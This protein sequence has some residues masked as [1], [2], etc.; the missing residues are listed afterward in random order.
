MFF[1]RSKV[2]TGLVTFSMAA[3][4]MGAPVKAMGYSARLDA[5]ADLNPITGNVI[6]PDNAQAELVA[7]AVLSIVGPGQK[8][9]VKKD[10]GEKKAVIDAATEKSSLKQD[11]K[12]ELAVAA[13]NVYLNIHT[14]ASLGSEVIGK[15]YSN[16][17]AKILQDN[18]G[19]WVKIKS[20][21]LV[22]YVLGEYLVK[23]DEAALLSELV[24]KNVAVVDNSENEVK[25]HKNKSEKNVIMTVSQ[26]E[27]IE[28]RE[29][30]EEETDGWIEVA[31]EK[32]KGYVKMEDV[33]V[34]DS[35]PVAETA[36]EQQERIENA[37]VKDIADDAQKKAEK[38][39]EVAQA[40]AQKAEE[41]ASIIEDENAEP[42]KAEEKA[43]ETALAVAE[44]AQTAADNTKVTYETA[45]KEMLNH[46][47]ETGQAVADFALQFV[48]NPYVWGGSSLTHGTDCS[49]FT[50]AVYS[51]F[52]VGLP[53][54]D[55]SQRGYGIGIDSL[56]DARPGD[57]ICFYGHVGIYIGDGMMVHAS[58]ARD[59]IKVSRA[60]YRAI[61]AIR[62]IFY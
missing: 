43:A 49:G 44:K 17:V 53:H 4:V 37:T 45:K 18:G 58:N 38:A 16:D 61:A 39:S 28:V 2:L 32:G 50:M 47:A 55:A 40:A 46:G 52:G 1:T 25:V 19:D 31:T 41:A 29:N 11:E 13:P 57:L 42:T 34:T 51:N 56:S 5:A 54:Y 60:D 15:L 62:R 30:M 24:K 22:G 3:A 7:D 14:D 59:G 33:S 35:Y 27:Q 8:M 26:G 10:N 21:S 36:E 12:I 48:G 23:G 9:R 6:T 20:G